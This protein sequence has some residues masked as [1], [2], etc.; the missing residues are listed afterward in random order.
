MSA[1][2]APLATLDDLFDA[3]DAAGEALA[4]G[5]VRGTEELELE[6][7]L[8]AELTTVSTTSVAEVLR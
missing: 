4:V 2:G 5:V 7:G 3:L 1:G 6:I 8:A